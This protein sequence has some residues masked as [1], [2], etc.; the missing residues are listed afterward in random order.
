MN[1]GRYPFDSHSC[2]ITVSTFS[3]SANDI[4]IIAGLNDEKTDL[5][6][7][8]TFMCVLNAMVFC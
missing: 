1:F 4:N 5:L 6:D 7:L 3:Q 2:S 8:T